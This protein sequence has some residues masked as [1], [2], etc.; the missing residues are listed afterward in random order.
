M[1]FL[2]SI[3]G[4]AFAITLIVAF[5]EFGHFST[6]KMAGVGVNE[7]AI[8]FGP[9]VLGTKRGD[10]EYALRAIPLGGYVDLVGMEED[11]EATEAEKHR[12]F[13]GKSAIWRITI[14]FAGSF[15]N[16]VLAFLLLFFVFSFTGRPTQPMVNMTAAGMVYPDTPAASAGILAGD[17][18]LAVN[19][20][21]IT[22]WEQF[23]DL[24]QARLN[25]ET[26][27]Q[28][29]RAGQILDLKVSPA[30][31]GKDLSQGKIGVA[32]AHP[33]IMGDVHPT[34]PAWQEGFRPAD[35]VIAVNGQ[36]IEYFFQVRELVKTAYAKNETISVQLARL[37]G[38]TTLSF[39]PVFEE[40]GLIPG[41]APAIGGIN[42][43]S[44]AALGGM[45]DGDLVVSISGTPI[46][47]W[48]EMVAHFTINAGQ[49]LAVEVLGSNGELRQLSLV[50]KDYGDGNGRVGVMIKTA[51]E[52]PLGL[53][54]GCLLAFDT[55]VD[56]TIRTLDGLWKLVAGALSMDYVSGPVGIA[57]IVGTQAK[58]GFSS[59]LRI[60]ALLSI[61]IGLL[62]LF[63]IPGLDG[64]RILFVFIEIIRRRKLSTRVEEGIHTVG[65][66]LLITLIV[67]VTFQDIRKLF[68]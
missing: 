56:I 59:L 35:K 18:F 36:P 26:I 30:A 25:Q 39:K 17:R 55:T 58:E 68:M 60:T 13:S 28:I 43:G 32:P 57:K 66:V 48:Q 6:A 5:H 19:G 38:E 46:Q 2:F 16:W 10:T 12:E 45:Q 4:L 34:S 24:I 47:T 23:R 27:L 52:P 44:P 42:T 33:A 50:P 20:Q 22:S 1:T 7:F 53:V 63:P 64:S 9:R 37:T 65:M 21:A 8:G 14:L 67:L 41:F 29:S 54:V 40:L 11:P 31:L 3:L 61:N 51:Y 62:N 15:M 49:T